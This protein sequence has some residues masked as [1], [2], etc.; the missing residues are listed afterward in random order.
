M[1]GEWPERAIVAVCVLF[2][3]IVFLLVGLI[4]MTK[5]MAYCEGRMDAAAHEVPR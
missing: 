5:R 1:M 3:T 4:T 2:A